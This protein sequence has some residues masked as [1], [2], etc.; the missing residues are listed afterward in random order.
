M[1]E[2]SLLKVAPHMKLLFEIKLFLNEIVWINVL[3]INLISSN[4]SVF[5]YKFKQ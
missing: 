2:Y 3:Q 4:H 5:E 1:F